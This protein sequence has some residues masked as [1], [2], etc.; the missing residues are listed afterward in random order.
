MHATVSIMFLTAGEDWG[1][2][3]RNG[4]DE[5]AFPRYTDGSQRVVTRDHPTGEM[6]G[7]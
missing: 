6:S 2:D 1:E 4:I 3:V 5:T 7:T